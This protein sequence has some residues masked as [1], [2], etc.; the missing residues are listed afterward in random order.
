MKKNLV[1]EVTPAE[2]LCLLSRSRSP[3]DETKDLESLSVGELMLLK[4]HPDL[5]DKYLKD[6]SHHLATLSK[7]EEISE[8]DKLIGELIREYYGK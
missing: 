7:D 4:A 2:L 1:N 6:R 5:L 3:I 8:N